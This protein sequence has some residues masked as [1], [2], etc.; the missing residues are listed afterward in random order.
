MVSVAPIAGPG[1]GRLALVDMDVA[2]ESAVFVI[3]S[4]YVPPSLGIRLPSGTESDEFAPMEEVW[5][6]GPINEG[7]AGGKTC[8]P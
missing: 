5:S 1:I 8:P 6:L 2:S 4:C 7:G 3:S